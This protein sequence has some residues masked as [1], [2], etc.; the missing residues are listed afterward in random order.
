M[1]ASG[2]FGMLVSHSYQN[3]R[4][5]NTLDDEGGNILM[6]NKGECANIPALAGLGEQYDRL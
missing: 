4:Q 5:S 6:R 1:E 3:L 2:P